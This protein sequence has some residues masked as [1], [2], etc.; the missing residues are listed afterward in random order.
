MP[1]GSKA[2]SAKHDLVLVASHLLYVTLPIISVTVASISL[3]MA[4][5]SF[6]E[7]E[8]LVEYCAELVQGFLQR[9]ISGLI[10]TME[11]SAVGT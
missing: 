11:Q 6:D 5:V 9:D 2:E 10:N 7:N 8:G 4:F 1:L 3:L